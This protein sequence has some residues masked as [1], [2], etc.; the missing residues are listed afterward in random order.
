M[1]LRS[2]FILCLLSLAVS[3]PNK[4]FDTKYTICPNGWMRFGDSCYYYERK[5]MTFDKAE[6]HCLQL[7]GTMF[8][9]DTVQEWDMVVKQSHINAWSWVGLKQDED[10]RKPRWTE[11]GGIPMSA[12]K[13]LSGTNGWSTASNCVAYYNSDVNPYALFYYC[14]LDYHP[15]CEK[16][17]TLLAN[18]WDPTATGF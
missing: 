1:L 14:G 16:N 15:I 13:W 7:G 8:V 17:A 10:E 2:L 5:K 6:V 12:I 11:T 4:K 3:Y 9:A 18:I